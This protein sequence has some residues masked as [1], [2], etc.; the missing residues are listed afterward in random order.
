MFSYLWGSF[1]VRLQGLMKFIQLAWAITVYAISLQSTYNV[2]LVTPDFPNETKCIPTCMPGSS[3]MHIVTYKCIQKH[4]H[5]R[6]R[7]IIRDLRFILESKAPNITGSRLGLRT[8]S[9]SNIFTSSSC[10]FLLLSNIVIARVSTCRTQQVWK[11]IWMQ[12]LYSCNARVFS[13]K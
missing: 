12:R 1:R 13:S 6:K 3:F 9:T 5:V 2:L 10:S 8:P 11:N 7:K 4:Y